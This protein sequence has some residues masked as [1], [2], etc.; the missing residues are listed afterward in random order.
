MLRDNNPWSAVNASRMVLLL[1]EELSV[2]VV[3]LI[4]SVVVHHARDALADITTAA[5]ST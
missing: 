2:R 3:D 4:L 5:A 1:E